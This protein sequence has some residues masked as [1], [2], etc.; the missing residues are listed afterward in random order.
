MCEWCGHDHEDEFPA[1][2]PLVVT[3][4]GGRPEN[5]HRGRIS[6]VRTDSGEEL[7][8]F[9][10]TK[11]RAFI[12][13]TGKPMQA[14][15]PLLG[16]VAEAFGWEDRHLAM[17]AA[18]H[19]GHPAQMA[20]LDDMLAKSGVPEEAY[21]FGAGAPINVRSRDE[22]ARGGG[23]PRKAFH[24]CAGKHLGMLAWCK[25]QG[26]PL[27]GYERP[28]HP[29]QQ[30]ILRRVRDWLGAGEAETATGKDGCGLPV[31][32]V[33]LWRVAL[34]YGR[35]ACPDAAPDREAAEAVAKVTAAMNRCPELVEGSGRLAS[36]LLADPNVVA[37]S[38]AQGLF[39]FGLRK[40]RIGVAIHLS[41]GSEASWGPIVISLLERLGGVSEATMETL[42]ERFPRS[43]ENDAG[44]VAGTR[45]VV[46]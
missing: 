1:D 39:A 14:I 8:A 2:V 10:D 27:A 13:S 25:L 32:A 19:R 12:R 11:A 37:K 41:D 44:A 46:F 3:T 36:L 22:W 34:G 18:S 33:P 38:G 16:G 28:E 15:E 26:W 29:A 40:E 9:G 20:A 6:V 7:E 30:R 21:V 24:T 4:R 35:L 42:R 45:D 23:A 5:R 43:F 17:L 31:V